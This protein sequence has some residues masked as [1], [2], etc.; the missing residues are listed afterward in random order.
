MILLRGMSEETVESDGSVE[1]VYIFFLQE[2]Q[3]HVRCDIEDTD[4]IQRGRKMQS[5][6]IKGYNKKLS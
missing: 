5:I 4:L 1:E 6:Y 2:M 3:S